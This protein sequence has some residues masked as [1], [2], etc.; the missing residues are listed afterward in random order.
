M[1]TRDTK[2]YY[3]NKNST[4]STIYININLLYI[5]ICIY[6]YIDIDIDKDKYLYTIG[7]TIT[8]IY[9][10]ILMN[11]I[12]KSEIKYIIDIFTDAKS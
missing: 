1:F 8:N 11:S 5:Y 7:C 12:S 4:K 10:L 9:C 3:P 2:S 6:I